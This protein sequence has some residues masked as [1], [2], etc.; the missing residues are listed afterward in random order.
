MVSKLAQELRCE[1]RA[2]RCCVWRVWNVLSQEK[3]VSSVFKEDSYSGLRD[4][5]LLFIPLFL[6][7]TVLVFIFEI[8]C[9]F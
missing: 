6:T 3:D 4:V 5:L 9:G 8:S 7:V 1:F 2:M